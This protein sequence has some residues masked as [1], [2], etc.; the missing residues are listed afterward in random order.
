MLVIA[1]REALG[2]AAGY[3]GQPNEAQA[4]FSEVLLALGPSA[5]PRDVCR[6][7]GQRAIAAFR[8]G[9]VAAAVEDHA[10]ALAL[11]EHHALDDLVCV[12]SLNLGTA[13]QQA[14]DLGAALRSYERGLAVARALGRESTELTLRYNLAN[15]RAVL[16]DFV[17][18]ERELTTL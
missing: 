15:L 11:A 17:G 13:E 5:P 4:Y 18:A 10:R 16:G 12:S 7:L 1:L 2:L 3:L 9:R 14:G 8:A 6:V